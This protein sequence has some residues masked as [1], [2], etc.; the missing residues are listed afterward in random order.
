MNFILT[1]LLF[2]RLKPPSD[3]RLFRW[4]SPEFPA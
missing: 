3:A 2:P 4:Y 1:F